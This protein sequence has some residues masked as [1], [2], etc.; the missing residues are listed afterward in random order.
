MT[1]PYSGRD[2]VIFLFFLLK[3]VTNDLLNVFVLDQSFVN[4]KKK[5]RHERFTNTHISNAKN[6]KC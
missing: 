3:L 2:T 5:K 6:F 4:V 1:D